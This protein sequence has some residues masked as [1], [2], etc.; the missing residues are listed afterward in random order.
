MPPESESFAYMGW[1][2]KLTAMGDGWWRA[3]AVY[4]DVDGR[5]RTAAVYATG[6][7]AA[8]A[9]LMAH[10]SETEDALCIA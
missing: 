1:G 8:W 7:D 6:R 10:I 4:L 9:L 2:V 3:S 5:P